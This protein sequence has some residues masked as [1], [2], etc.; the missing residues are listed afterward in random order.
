MAL[1]LGVDPGLTR[2]GYALVESNKSVLHGMFQ[3]D[4]DSDPAER[5]GKISLE[6][7][8]LVEKYQPSLI[9]LE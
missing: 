1:I 5:V 2:C 6:L 9:A 4:A 8:Q 7:E 3:S